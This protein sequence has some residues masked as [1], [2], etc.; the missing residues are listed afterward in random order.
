MPHRPAAIGREMLVALC[1]HVVFEPISLLIVPRHL[2]RMQQ[3]KSGRQCRRVSNRDS[4]CNVTGG[5]GV[6]S[7][8]M[9][10]V[11]PNAVV[12][13]GSG[14]GALAPAIPI[15]RLIDHQRID[16]GVRVKQRCDAVSLRF[17]PQQCEVVGCVVDD[18]GNVRLK[19][20]T[21]ISH[22]LGH[23][24]GGWTA[25]RAGMGRGDA[26][27]RG[28]PLR[29]FYSGVGKPVAPSHESPRGV[30]YGNTRGHDAGGSNIDPRR[31][32]I[33]HGKVA[34]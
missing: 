3:L 27:N 30:E 24:L 26:V 31:L 13:C 22:D 33:K 10:S 5:N 6:D 7:G 8:V 28:R 1:S 20:R 11:E 25:L 29:N 9:G 2:R 16:H 34:L 32:K 4:A 15:C 19:M 17:E 12:R 23:Y 14:E 21:Q 18:E